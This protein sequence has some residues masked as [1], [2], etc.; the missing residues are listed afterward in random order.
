MWVCAAP[1][2]AFQRGDLYVWREAV[3][4]LERDVAQ[5]LLHALQRGRLKSVTLEVLSEVATQ[6][7]EVSRG[8]AWRVWRSRR[9]LAHFAV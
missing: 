1:A 2:T 5:P 7:F 3:L 8:G 9:P 4:A 6:R